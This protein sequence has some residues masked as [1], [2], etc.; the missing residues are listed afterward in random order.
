MIINNKNLIKTIK[1]V[2]L[3]TEQEANLNEISNIKN[4]LNNKVDKIIG[5][6]LSTEDYTSQE[7]TDLANL[8]TII[9]DNNSGLVK[10]V[11]DLKNNGVSQD[12][13]NSAIEDYLT[14]HPVQSG[15]TAEQAAQIA[16][17]YSHSQSHHVA[18]SDIPT[19]TSQLFNDSGFLTGISN[20]EI[21]NA[22]GYRN[23]NLPKEIA[24][25][26]KVYY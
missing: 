15:A 26:I 23:C 13:I 16:T 19:K 11:T 22:N 20:E 25:D 18:V 5:K 3:T 21:K 4:N 12:N 14:Q 17:A 24:K 2:D 6:Q 10:D 8:K 9:G 1:R 7:K